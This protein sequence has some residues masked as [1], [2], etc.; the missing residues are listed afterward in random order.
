MV[1]YLHAEIAYKQETQAEFANKHQLPA[2]ILQVG[3]EVWLH[4]RFIN[5]TRP[6][7]KLD[8][9]RL[10]T[11]KIIDRIG[12]HAYR[13]A[14]P[15]TMKIHPVFHASLL[16]PVATNPLPGQRIPP[17]PPMEVDGELEW[18]VQEILDSR[19]HGRG[20]TKYTQ[21]LVRWVGHDHPTWEPASFLA[22]APEIV[23]DFHL[24]YPHKPVS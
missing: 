4:R 10:G 9:K 1:E 22:N 17:N 15:P 8:H 23:Q 7:N 19:V 24:R 12:T 11:F 6:S 13:L 5:T 21:Y 18:E 2:P 3:D 16:E 14:L 20:Q